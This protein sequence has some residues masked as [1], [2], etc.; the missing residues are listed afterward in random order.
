[1]WYRQLRTIVCAVLEQQVLFIDWQPSS[2]TST[3]RGKRR[4]ALELVSDG[5]IEGGS[6]GRLRSP[7]NDDVDEQQ[8]HPLLRAEI[9]PIATTKTKGN[10][11]PLPPQ[12]PVFPAASQGREPSPSASAQTREAQ[13]RET[14]QQHFNEQHSIKTEKNEL[15]RNR[16]RT[17]SAKGAQPHV[18]Q[19]HFIQHARQ[20]R[21][22]NTSNSSNGTS[23]VA[24]TTPAGGEE[25]EETK[26]LGIPVVVWDY[27]EYVVGAIAVLILL[28]WLY[29]AYESWAEEQKL[30]RD[31][32]ERRR[33]EE[34]EA[35]AGNTSDVSV[36]SAWIED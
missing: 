10:A 23:E 29:D 21:S 31:A 25:D 14:R 5:T 8:H 7:S 18:V 4:H 33:R 15:G 28:H 1:M 13:A 12:P 19:L 30:L 6:G 17:R 16:R 24:T 22:G 34:A 3:R 35:R 26:F 32:E 2:A 36:D 9:D 27:V 11:Q 20:Q